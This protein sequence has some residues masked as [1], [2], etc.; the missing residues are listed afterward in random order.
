[1]KNMYQ[2]LLLAVALMVGGQLTAQRIVTIADNGDPFTPVNIFPVIM[3]DTTATGERVDNNTV[4]ELE[5]GVVYITTG[6]I[7]NKPEW[8]LQIRAV[9]TE[10]IDSKAIITR[11]PNATGDYPDI[12][13]PEGDVTLTNLWI[14]AG[15]RGALQQHDWGKIR[16]MGENTRVTVTDC[17]I[18]KDRGGFLQVRADGIKMYVDG[19]I[20]RNGGNRRVIQGN[21]RGVDCR[22]FSMDTLI[23][24]NTV[25]HN[26]QDRF[27]RSQGASD[28]HNY[29]EIDHCTSFNTVGRHGHIQLGR[30]RTAK[31]TNNL[32]SNPIMLGSSPFYTDEQ[33]QPDNDLHSV[34]TLDTLLESTTLEIS[35]NNI[36]W[37]E[38]VT[39]YWASVDTINA[40]NVL[41]QLVEQSL[42]ADAANAS[43]SEPLSLNNVPQTIL[44]YVQDLYTN[45]AAEDMFDFIVEDDVLDG[46]PFDSG[47]LFDFDDFDPCY[48]TDAVSATAAIDGGGVGVRSFCPELATSLSEVVN[49]ALA[50]EIFPNPT[51]EQTTFRFDLDQASEVR[52]SVFSLSGQLVGQPVNA[53]LPSGNHNFNWN[54]NLPKGMYLVNLQTEM[55]MMTQKL[56]V[57]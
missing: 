22:D 50:L 51:T 45:P 39:N 9:D 13:R 11:V 26:I 19:C 34:I 29:I 43:F 49:E 36:F 35:N 37:T 6:R 56:V 57:R 32:F 17:I 14:I 33:T 46:T 10:N 27:M 28:P 48:S 4:Y 44:E 31:I 55:G 40:P 7:V 38:D 52:V 2:L 16:F 30:V 24:R 18:E 47:N 54:I 42:G 23:M 8:P 41:S 21:G 3:G 5:N 15:E 12:M 25:V 1:M 20:F 53:M